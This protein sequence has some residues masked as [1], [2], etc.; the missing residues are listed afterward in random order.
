MGILGK[1]FTWISQ[2]FQRSNSTMAHAD[3]LIYINA[4]Q[5]EERDICHALTTIINNALVGAVSK[6]WHAHPVWFIDENPIVGFSKQK[7]GI[8]LMFW[9]GA[10]FDEPLLTSSA[11]KFQDASIFYNKLDEILEIDVVRWLEK[12]I[13]IQWDYKNIVKRKGVLLRLR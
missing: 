12:S 1:S 2:N 6:L 7:G 3:I 13:L 10:D 5:K 9:S 11:G 4:L 8:R